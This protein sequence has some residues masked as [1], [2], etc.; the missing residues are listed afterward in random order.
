MLCLC[1]AVHLLQVLVGFSPLPEEERRD[2]PDCPYADQQA[3]L[4]LRKQ[5][6]ACTG[7]GFTETAPA[8]D[9][10]AQVRHKIERFLRCAALFYHFYTDVLLPPELAS[11]SIPP[12]HEALCRYLGL[13]ETLR[14]FLLVLG[15]QVWHS[16]MGEPL[17]ANSQKTDL[18]K[19]FF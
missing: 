6:C 14:D 12:T 19:N 16:T 1:L 5:V 13:P 2:L 4:R 3:L 9:F 11:T 7:A 15:V 18:K 8:A 17:L 10:G